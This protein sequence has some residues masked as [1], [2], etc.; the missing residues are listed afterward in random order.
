LNI[1]KSIKYVKYTMRVYDN[2]KKEVTEVTTIYF[3]IT[4]LKEIKEDLSKS[5]LTLLEIINTEYFTKKYSMEINEFIENA[6]E[7]KTEKGE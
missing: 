6:S 1:T 5:A 3:K 7:I 4:T 2:V